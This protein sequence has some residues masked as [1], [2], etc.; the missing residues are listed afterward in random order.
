MEDQAPYKNRRLNTR[1]S[2]QQLEQSITR[3]REIAVSTREKLILDENRKA[4]AI[5]AQNQVLLEAALD[6]TLKVTDLYFT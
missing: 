4:V 6:K 2:G 1:P 3:I 5:D